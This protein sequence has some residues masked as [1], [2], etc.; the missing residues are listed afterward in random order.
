METLASFL[1]SDAVAAFVGDNSWGWPL[2]EVSH[3]VGMA[4]L[5]GTVG[6]LDLRILGVAKGVPIASLEKLIAV[7][8]I[9]FLMNL[10]SGLVFVIGNPVGGPLDYL[11][12]LAFQLKMLLILCAGINLLAFYATGIARAADSVG[13]GGNASAAAKAVATTS[14]VLWFAVIVFGRLIMYNDTL[15]YA[16]GL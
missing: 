12:N 9:G 7:G 16:F 10:G 4:L 2:C 11:G 14:L 3:F 6:L 15:L 5:I 13:A 1:S 8:I